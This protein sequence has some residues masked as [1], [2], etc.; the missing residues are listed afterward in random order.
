MTEVE[1]VEVEVNGGGGGGGRVAE[2]EA[3]HHT[4]NDSRPV[5]TG[6]DM[7]RY[8]KAVVVEV[9]ASVMA[10]LVDD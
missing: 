8:R 6:R 10:V 1:L 7:G 3:W 5:Q 2:V 9:E 4:N